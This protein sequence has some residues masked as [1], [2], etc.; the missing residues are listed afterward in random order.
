MG[1][2][3]RRR[4]GGERFERAA[5]IYRSIV[6]LY[7]EL[8]VARTGAG[9]SG[10]ADHMDLRVRIRVRPADRRT[11]AGIFARDLLAE[12]DRV[13]E[14]ALLAERSFRLGRVFCHWCESAEC[15]HAGP[16]HPKSVFNGYGPTGLPLWSDFASVCLNTRDPRIDLLYR[17]SPE[18]IAI[19]QAG[20]VLRAA[21]L[22]VFG[23]RS[24]VYGIVGQVIAGYL[25]LRIDGQYASV[26][27]TV[28]VVQAE[29]PGR[30]PRLGMN[31]IGRS[32]AGTDLARILEEVP[33]DR[34]A[35]I[36]EQGR[37]KIEELDVRA[38]R[39]LPRREIDALLRHIAAGLERLYRQ[40]GRRT[41]HGEGRHLEPGRPAAAALR[42]ARAAP[43]ERCFRDAA[44]GTVVVIGPKNRVHIFAANGRHVTSATYAGHAIQRR[45]NGGKWRRM[46]PED[47]RT[48]VE[49]LAPREEEQEGE[50]GGSP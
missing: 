38:R 24:T 48:F 43:I 29:S 26:A 33:D 34:L 7:D 2:R 42:D 12:I 36:L 21:Q 46:T 23:G 13:V 14:G 8:R 44:E 35:R 37:R 47:H 5:A 1:G 10:V 15:Q 28:Q 9:E 45:I 18:P 17:A 39:D 19:V 32:P 30:A 40:R 16:P 4:G 49:A 31:V 6:D 41:K 27:L 22:G 3:K 20:E 25:P 11:G 50:G